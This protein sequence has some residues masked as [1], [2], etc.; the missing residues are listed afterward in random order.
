M[1]H[2][3]NCLCTNPQKL[4]RRD[5]YEDFPDE[6]KEEEN[7]FPPLNASE[8]TLHLKVNK[9]ICR[10]GGD[11]TIKSESN[12]HLQRL[13][14][15]TQNQFE[16]RIGLLWLD[17]RKALTQRWFFNLIFKWWKWVLNPH[18][19]WLNPRFDLYIDYVNDGKSFAQPET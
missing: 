11:L 2:K 14:Y 10:N 5:Y 9:N 1:I 19:G 13:S 18:R 12:P 4:G 7:N 3:K 17:V 6:G 15:G 8:K 16:T